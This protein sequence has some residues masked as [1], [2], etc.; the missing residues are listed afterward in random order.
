MGACIKWFLE[1]PGRTVLI[2]TV[3][4]DGVWIL[5]QSG[6]KDFLPAVCPAMLAHDLVVE[7][8]GSV[9][10]LTADSDHTRRLLNRD[11]PAR[12]SIT[13]GVTGE[14]L[15]IMGIIFLRIQPRLLFHVGTLSGL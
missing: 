3:D 11:K 5:V 14:T 8:T 15:G 12:F 13:R 6:T 4:T 10:F 2:M 1:F 7:F 9:T